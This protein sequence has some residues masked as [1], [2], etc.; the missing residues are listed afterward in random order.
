M[1]TLVP[2]VGALVVAG[3]AGLGVV[4]AA[5]ASPPAG[6]PPGSVPRITVFA[7]ADLVLAFQD[8]IPAF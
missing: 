1:K 7:A 8:L 4:S 6:Q 3:F 5:A 2:A